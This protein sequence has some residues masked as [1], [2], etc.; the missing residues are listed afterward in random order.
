MKRLAL[1]GKNCF[2]G[3]SRAMVIKVT[4]RLNDLVSYRLS[5]FLIKL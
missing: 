2:Y 4:N 3:I 1:P 5:V